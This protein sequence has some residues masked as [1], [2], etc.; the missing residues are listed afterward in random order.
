MKQFKILPVLL[1]VFLLTS[2]ID[3]DNKPIGVGDVL[4]VSKQVGN[5]TVYGISIY[6]YSLS[7][8]ESV[9]AVSHADQA[10]T[11][12]LKANQD[13]KTNFY[14][15]MPDTEYTTTKPVATTYDFT[16]VFSDGSTQLFQDVLTDKVLPLPTIEKC[17]YNTNIHAL[18]VAWTLIENASSYAINILDGQTLVFGTTELIP[19]NKTYSVRADGRGWA[20]GFTPQSGKTYTVKVFAYLYEQAGNSYNIQSTSVS[21]KTV[22]WGD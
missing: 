2:C 1:S 20:N 10:K 16:A 7:P 12:T 22:V 4:M 14:Y 15:E 21:E 11:Y 13:Y 17:A 19:T 18:E 8:F 9:K 6:A 3:N 5:S